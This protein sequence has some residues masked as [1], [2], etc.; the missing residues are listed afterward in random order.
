MSLKCKIRFKKV[1]KLIVITS[2]KIV[3]VV[4]KKVIMTC[5]NPFLNI[6]ISQCF[7]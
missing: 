3:T 2:A 5:I 1:L 4:R 7:I 6:S